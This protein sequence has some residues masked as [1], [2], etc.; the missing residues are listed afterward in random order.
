MPSPLRKDWQ[1]Y[2]DILRLERG[3]S[4]HTL[5]GYCRDLGRF[6]DYLESVGILS[7]AR[8]AL[9]TLVDFLIEQR[10]RGL[11]PAS[12]A[13]MAASLRGFLRFLHAEGRIPKELANDLE[14]PAAWHRIP[15]FLGRSAMEELLRS[16]DHSAIGL[17]DRAI[18]EAMYATGARASEVIGLKMQDV[19]LEY[20]Y[21]R[22]FGKGNKERIVPMAKE[23]AIAIRT[24]LREGRP[25]LQKPESPSI[26]FLSRTGGPLRRE[27]LWRIVKRCVRKAGVSPR[28]SPHTLRHTFATHLLEGGADL[29]SLQEMLGH[30]NV[31]TT[32]IYTH[33]DRARLKSIHQK[34]HPRG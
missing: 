18:L 7:P 34:F 23:A 26:L 30:V 10:E 27:S 32:Q 16:P 20:R 9:D 6:V 19:H 31:Q 1:E 21:V 25:V 4:P 24:Y 13:R 3:H 29:R 2:R 28:V 17:R 15:F 14:S 22:C 33:V 12:I 5:D 11:G 8:I